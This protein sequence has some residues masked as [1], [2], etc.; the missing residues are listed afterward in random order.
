MFHRFA[1]VANVLVMSGI[2]K[3][4]NKL[5]GTVFEN[6]PKCLAFEFFN[7]GVYHQFLSGNTV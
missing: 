1:P 4:V 2:V 6:H 7:F 5:K 3:D